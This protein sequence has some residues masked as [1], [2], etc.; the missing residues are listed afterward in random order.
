MLNTIA[1]PVAQSIDMGSLFL[2]IGAMVVLFCVAYLFYAVAHWYKRTMTK[3][4]QLKEAYGDVEENAVFKYAS[5]KGL[6]ILKF[7]KM[8]EM[9]SRK[10]TF[11]KRLEAEVTKDVFGKEKEDE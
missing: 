9:A 7:R 4:A 11:R 2:G 8:M 3:D 5:K 1:Q 10:K 6:D